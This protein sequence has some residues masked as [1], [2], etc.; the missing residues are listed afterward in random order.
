M[1]A[2]AHH[3]LREINRLQCFDDYIRIA[4]AQ[5]ASDRENER[6]RDFIKVIE[7]LRSEGMNEA[8]GC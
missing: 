4:R 2:D 3:T 5:M 8:L 6:L 1:Q 7:T